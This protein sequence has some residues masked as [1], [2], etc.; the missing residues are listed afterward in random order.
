MDKIIGLKKAVRTFALDESEDSPVYTLDLTDK[1]IAAK[2][3]AVARQ[4]AEFADLGE[5]L[6]SCKDDEEAERLLAKTAELYEGVIS[7]LLGKKAYEEIVEYVGGGSD[8]SDVNMALTPLVVYLLS[9]V[10]ETVA[11]NDLAASAKYLRGRDA[12]AAV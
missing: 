10:V 7:V 9:E 11:A 12:V 3:H 4:Q 6:R 2:L 8:A 1:G 5:R